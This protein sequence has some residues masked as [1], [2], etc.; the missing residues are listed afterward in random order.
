MKIPWF[1]GSATGPRACGCDHRG[2]QRNW[3]RSGETVRSSWLQRRG[4]WYM[5][6]LVYSDYMHVNIFNELYNYRQSKYIVRITFNTHIGTCAAC[7][8]CIL[9]CHLYI[10]INIFR[11]YLWFFCV[12]M[13]F[14]FICSCLA[15]ASRATHGVSK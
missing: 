11:V 9:Y 6:G 1:F 4:A 3:L 14:I 5:G 2:W 13:Y 15:V 8:I 10:Y 7:I 12:N